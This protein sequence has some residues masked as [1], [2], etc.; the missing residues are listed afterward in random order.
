MYKKEGGGMSKA[1]KQ[2]LNKRE[3]LGRKPKWFFY[4]KMNKEERR[5]EGKEGWRWGK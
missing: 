3:E 4:R 1:G 2:R 5:E